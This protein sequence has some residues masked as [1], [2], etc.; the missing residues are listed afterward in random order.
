MLITTC[1]HCVTRFRV[2][3]QQLNAKQGQVRCGRCNKVFSGFEAL[4][5]FPDDDT[6]ARLLAAME[7][8]ALAP[9]DPLAGIEPLPVD[10]GPVDALP[11]GDLPPLEDLP[12]IETLDSPPPPP[13]FVEQPAA[14]STPMGRP[15]GA[16]RRTAAAIPLSALE[17]PVPR[18]PSRAWSL[19]VA[20]L[21]LVLA[22][23]LGF[24]FRGPIAQRYPVLRPWLESA[25]ANAGCV[26]PWLRDERLLKLE[27]SELLEVPGRPSEINLG[28]R[29][30]NL[31]TGAQ[32]Y[33]HLELTLT[34]LSGQAAARRV[35][36]PIDYM[37]RAVGAGEVL[38]P[39][40]E[41]AIQLRLETPR[42]KA[43]G[44]ELLLFYP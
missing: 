27:D 15:H 42:I 32:E 4:E 30:R 37:G 20:L 24:A 23:E 6:G 34:D 17:P 36:R 35:L 9:G 1:T 5:R 11:I 39:G 44:Y 21:A 19:G 14:P 29:V 31:A 13:A 8:S 28:A 7:A 2:T 41:V 33:P 16:P 38:A 12:D 18:K 43:T 10:D 25:C 22:G 3:P 26:V 40:A